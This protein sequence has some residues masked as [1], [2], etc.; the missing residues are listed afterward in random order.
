MDENYVLFDAMGI[1]KPFPGNVAG[2]AVLIS[3]IHSALASILD[4]TV[5]GI[6]VLDVSG[7]IVLANKKMIQM[8]RE[9]YG[10][11]ICV[12]RYW[13]ELEDRQLR[14]FFA[15]FFQAYTD[16]GIDEADRH[17]ESIH[18]KFRFSYSALPLFNIEHHLFGIAGVFKEIHRNNTIE[19]AFEES[20]WKFRKLI[21]SVPT[22][23]LIVDE[24]MNIVSINPMGE[25]IFGYSQD[26]LLFKN[27]RILLPKQIKSEY[28]Y[29][30]KANA[31]RP[32]FSNNKP[33][34]LNSAVRKDGKEIMIELRMSSFRFNES[35]K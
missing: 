30:N 16:G 23:I 28:L 15:D 17:I 35:V 10:C 3:A 20:E 7:K 19:S 29:L 18:G 12:G 25:N 1:K 6:I 5:E 22:P 8:V 34:K 4:S 13:T 2:N 26:E 31:S 11:E 14:S 24:N 9:W 33:G 27:V 21:E 32:E